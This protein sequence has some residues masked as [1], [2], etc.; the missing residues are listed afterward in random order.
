VL[1]GGVGTDKLYGGNGD[2]TFVISG[3]GDASDAFFGGDGTDR[4]QVSGGTP[5]TLAGFS[6]AASSIEVW[7]GND[8]AVLGTSKANFLDFSGLDA[9]TGLLYVDGGKGN[10]TITG[11]NFADDLRGGAD[12]DTLNG[13][14]GSDNVNGGAGHDQLYG[15]D[16]DDMLSGGAGNDL[17]HGGDGDDIMIGGAGK[18]QHFGGAGADTFVFAESGSKN[19]DTI[20]DYNFAEGD[21]IDLSALLDANFNESSLVSD[22]VRLTLSGNDLLLQIDANG[23]ASGAKFVDVAILSGY[24]TAGID[25]VLV[26]FEQQAHILAA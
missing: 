2:D 23:A 20:F 5:V 14:G 8:Y 19:R 10:D 9:V 3:T 12:N 21:A 6:A 13:G 24:S 1:I 15:G 18:D 11:T 4:I 7:E 16:G 26:Q 22:F 25:Q 17:L